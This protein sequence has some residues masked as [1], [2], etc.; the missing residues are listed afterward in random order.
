[1]VVSFTVAAP[2]S[3]GGSSFGE[4]GPPHQTHRS[5]HAE[6]FPGRHTSPTRSSGTSR[7]M[8]AKRDSC[9][10]T[11]ALL[12]AT[13][14]ARR[15]LL[16]PVLD[17]DR[18]E[19][20]RF[21]QSRARLTEPRKFRER[22]CAPFVA[23]TWVARISSTSQP[24]RWPRRPR[25]VAAPR[26]PRLGGRAAEQ[27]DARRDR[28]AGEHCRMARIAQVG[29]SAAGPLSSRVMSRSPSQADQWSSRW[30][31][32]R[33]AYVMGAVF[34]SALALVEELGGT[35]AGAEGGEPVAGERRP[36]RWRA[37]SAA[38]SRP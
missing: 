4:T 19:V 36:G 6:R 2:F 21:L 3:L 25:G 35:G 23:Q 7:A 1:M 12:L 11:A 24:R 9:L 15:D 37:G 22:V 33:I 32:T 27:R 20:P 16:S 30:P 8:A 28:N 26:S 10:H 5:R 17:D 31:S 29:S 13:C 38:A 18:R 14:G 34:M